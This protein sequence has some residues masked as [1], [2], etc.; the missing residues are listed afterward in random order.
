MALF[1]SFGRDLLFLLQLLEHY[2]RIVRATVLDS[3][4]KV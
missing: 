2:F 4:P 3:V 1:T